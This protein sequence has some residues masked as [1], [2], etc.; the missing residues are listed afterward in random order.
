MLI[1]YKEAQKYKDEMNHNCCIYYESVAKK[2]EEKEGGSFQTVLELSIEVVR[3]SGNSWSF[4][5]KK[6]EQK[7]KEVRKNNFP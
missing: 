6:V 2:L 5:F 4:K 3:F 1:H 7:E